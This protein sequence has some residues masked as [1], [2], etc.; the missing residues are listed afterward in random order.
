MSEH[1]ELLHWMGKR[2]EMVAHDLEVGDVEKAGHELTKIVHELQ[3]E[4][5]DE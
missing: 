3:R 2:L 5:S 4:C 1:D